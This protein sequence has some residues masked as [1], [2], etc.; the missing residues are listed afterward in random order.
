MEQAGSNT[1]HIIKWT[2]KA[3]LVLVAIALFW[4]LRKMLMSVFAAVLLAV[5]LDAL[6]I[7]LKKVTH[8]P[9]GLSLAIVCVLLIA[10]GIFMFMFL[11]PRVVDQFAGLAERIP[12]ALNQIQNWLEQSEMGQKILAFNPK[13]DSAISLGTKLMGGFVGIFSTGMD[14][15]AGLMIILFGGLYFAATP[16]MYLDNGLLLLPKKKRQRGGEV[17]SALGTGLRR[18][19]IG[20]FAAM[21]ITGTLVG[22]GL[23]IAG[24][25][26]ALSLGV[27]SGLLAFVPNIGPVISFLLMILVAMTKDPHL[28]IY[29]AFVYL[30]VQILESYVITPLVQERAVSIPPGFL[31]MVQILMGFL[32]G[33][34]GLFLATPMLVAIIIL[35]QTLYVNDHLG[36]NVR[37]IGH[38]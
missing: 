17:L 12:K 6:T 5:F 23:L 33:I 37:I 31:I 19:L 16:R 35:I 2:A 38:K 1:A 21:A 25:P 9:R 30:I 32:F 20:R 22:I 26:L 29:V 28:I 10:L 7:S 18:W 27:I 34:M 13:P 36:E 24:A 11:G 4:Y 3:A 14:I 15:F 8:I